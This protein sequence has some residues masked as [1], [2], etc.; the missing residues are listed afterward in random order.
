M[1]EVWEAHDEKLSRD[2]AAK[3]LQ[4][5]LASE[6]VFLERFR[7]EAV[8]A[9]RLAHPGIVATFDTGADDGT[10]FIV[11]ELVRGHNLRQVLSDDG[12]LEPWEA[13]A[14]ARQVADALAYSHQA[15]LVHRDIKP[16]NVLL[17]EDEFG[18][19]RVKVT[20]FGI[21][22]AG[23][24]ADQDLTRTGMV[25]GTPKY[26]SPEQIR[27]EEPDARADLYSLGV[28]LYEM[29]VG[30]PPFAAETDM[31]TALAHL[32]NP[33]PKPSSRVRGIPPELEQLVCEL[34]AKDPG[35]RP[36]S[37][38]ALRDRLD[39]LGPLAA[40]SVRSGRSAGRA[41]N[42][43]PVPNTT[44]LGSA[45]SEAPATVV[46]PV[47]SRPGSNGP[48][49]DEFR[50]A[51]SGGAYRRAERT[52]GIVV[53]ALLLIGAL[54][55]GVLYA[56]SKHKSASSHGHPA[57]TSAAAVH[58]ASVSVYMVGGRA[59]D[60]P[61]SVVYTYDGNPS[62]SWSTDHY[63]NSTFGNLYPGVG[64]SIQ[65]TSSSKLSQLD[66]TSS[67][68]GWA[69]S[70]YVSASAISTGQP[71]SA[72]GNPVD[73]KSSISGNATFSLGHKTG[74]YVLLFITNLGPADAATVNELTIH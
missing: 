4:A 20:D 7:R 44:V 27:G 39:R 62:T 28:V 42:G 45:R 51:R 54:V 56:S 29:L 23:A 34:L 47:A 57:G 59:P 8:N 43:G 16:A 38:V 2:V 40:P 9:A 66:V 6:A 19:L 32:N 73:S 69:A 36:P 11:M 72:W 68:V 22:K 65:L 70:V 25:L 37:A 35:R 64:L 60:N 5:H 26:L 52:A 18:G 31:A 30:A 14:V 17:I 49:T 55:A 71:V 10:A 15:G 74:R 21:A 53:L 24:G 3:V 41:G 50:A 58:I 67:T 13:V 33:V 61:G 63:S 46:S 1:A 12:P 48:N